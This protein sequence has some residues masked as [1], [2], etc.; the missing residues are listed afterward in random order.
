ME[1]KIKS[2]FKKKNVDKM[3]AE[4]LAV[5]VY[6]L[7]IVSQTPRNLESQNWISSSVQTL[8]VTDVGERTVEEVMCRRSLDS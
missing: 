2:A 6:L 7:L 1:W 8:R 3:T 4:E 5:M